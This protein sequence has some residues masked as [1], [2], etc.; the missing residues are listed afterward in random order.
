M[1]GKK[2]FFSLLLVLLLLGCVQ[3]EVVTL[4]PENIDACGNEVCEI[5]ENCENCPLDCGCANTE[6]CEES[7]RVCKAI[8]CGNGI[9]ET[10]ETKENCCIDTGCESE[11]ICNEVT[12][13]CMEK[14][15]ADE[16]IIG[17]IANDYI[18]ERELSASVESI[19][20]AYYGEEI[21]K[22]VKIK[23]D[24]GQET[25]CEIILYIGNDG[26]VLEEIRTTN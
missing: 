2:I 21:V 9:I 20:D 17:Q 19:T 6:Y 22:Q 23:C 16:N 11:Q 3:Q 18:T 12:Q 14:S 1:V 15:N 26:Q 7:S 10:G 8:V 24:I 4:T 13:K 25:P 5:T